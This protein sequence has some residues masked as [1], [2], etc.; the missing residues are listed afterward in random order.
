M[1]Y[2]ESVNFYGE[3]NSSSED[4]GDNAKRSGFQRPDSSNGGGDGEEIIHSDVL[5]VNTLMESE[6]IN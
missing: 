3:L 5:S 2:E 6:L 4:V 1:N